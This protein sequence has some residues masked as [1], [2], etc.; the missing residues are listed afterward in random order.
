M[1]T[2]QK[3]R[4]KSAVAKKI[5]RRRASLA[6]SAVILLAV[7]CLF[8]PAFGITD[9]A[10][11]GNRITDSESIIRAS[12]IKK[13]E[14]VFRIKTSEA[15]KSVGSLGYINNV[16]VKR[17]FPA[18]VVI[19]VEECSE[20]AYVLFAGN[21]VGID[22]NNRV[23][24]VSKSSEVSAKKPVVSGMALKSFK[25]GSEISAAKPEKEEAMKSLFSSLKK[26]NLFSKVKKIDLSNA[27]NLRIIL[28]TDTKVILGKNNQLDYKFT[29]LTEVLNNLD[30]LRG[31]E[32][33]LSDTKNVIYKG[34]N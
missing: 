11:R 1:R 26:H 27:N 34:G 18:R 6:V 28:N 5:K 2:E 3:L 31:G 29:Y 7:V 19:E 24:G 12:G 15:K 25:N 9:V 33:D 21:Y 32:I 4:K 10:V 22:L 13:G 16:E 20:A 23:M 17:K 8:T 30:N 14:N